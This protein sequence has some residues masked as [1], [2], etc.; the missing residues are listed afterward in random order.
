[1]TLQDDPR[2]EAVLGFDTVMSDPSGAITR[3]M[4]AGREFLAATAVSLTSMWPATSLGLDPA[5]SWM[6]IVHRDGK[7]LAGNRVAAGMYE[8][9][10]TVKGASG[11]VRRMKQRVLL[12]RAGERIAAG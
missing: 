6:R 12:E 10:Y 11:E 5:D 7:D 4:S 3:A 9:I 1:M 8:A 2:A